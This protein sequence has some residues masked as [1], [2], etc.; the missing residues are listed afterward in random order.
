MCKHIDCVIHSMFVIRIQTLW[1]TTMFVESTFFTY[2][3]AHISTSSLVQ[4]ENVATVLDTIRMPQLDSWE[5]VLHVQT[6]A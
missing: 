6:L 4:K 1:L 5:C 2:P 3:F